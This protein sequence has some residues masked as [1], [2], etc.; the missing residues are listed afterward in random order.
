MH[1]NKPQSV[2]PLNL[3]EQQIEEK[4]AKLRAKHGKTGNQTL[5][6]VQLIDAPRLSPEKASKLSEDL[7]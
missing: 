1:V 3:S 4:L 7:R 2:K 5:R 6:K